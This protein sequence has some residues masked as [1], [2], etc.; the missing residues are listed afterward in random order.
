MFHHR[1]IIAFSSL[2]ILVAL[3]GITSAVE[4]YTISPTGIFPEDVFNIQSV[5]DSL[6]SQGIDGKIVLAACNEA[7]VPTSFNFGEG[8][9]FSGE[10][11][12]V[13]IWG[14]EDSGDIAFVGESVGSAKTTIVGGIQSLFCTR[15]A[16]FEVRGIR[17]EGAEASPIMVYRCNSCEIK[18]NEIYDVRGD[19]I[20]MGPDGVP[21][22]VGIW[23][24]ANHWA[25]NNIRGSVEI[26]GN[27]IHDVIADYAFGIAIVCTNAS[28]EV[29][30]NEIFNVN[31]VG[32]LIS[33]NQKPVVIEKNLV[34]PGPGNTPSS[35][36]EGSG[37]HSNFQAPFSL[38]DEST[39]RVEK[40]R[41][42][43]ENYNASG[44][45]AFGDSIQPFKNSVIAKNHITMID[46]QWSA[47]DLGAIGGLG[48]FHN[49]VGGNI[50]DGQGN[51]AIF[52]GEFW[53]DALPSELSGNFFEKNNLN[54]YYSA[55][56]DVLFDEFTHNNFYYGR[57][58]I[59][60]DLG[61]ENVIVLKND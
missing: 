57:D 6:G 44:I 59:V 4:V 28:F 27:H 14:D 60:L 52:L 38:G 13:L 33:D 20:G 45:S 37:I 21:K 7:G 39:I 30:G 22:A 19:P 31:S 53:P 2:F 12:Y 11:W 49:Y 5:V 29:K 43:C 56:P 42:V 18:D 34:I 8:D 46:T 16:K 58:E 9:F 26:K 17:F 51:W 32:I 50:I 3:C 47:I 41:V 36:S 54:G 35:Y 25:I 23:I 1:K 10:R 40:N 24:A 55:G 48:F 15:P 61:Q